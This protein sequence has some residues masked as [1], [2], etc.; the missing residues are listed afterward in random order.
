MEAAPFL[1][2]FAKKQMKKAPELPTEEDTME[3][4]RKRQEEL[5]N[6]KGRGASLVTGGAGLTTSPSL[7][8]PS[9]LGAA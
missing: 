8:R 7:G 4:R 2:L 3:A 1:G 5:A 9:L 6:R